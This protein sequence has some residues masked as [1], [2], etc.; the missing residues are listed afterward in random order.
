MSENKR[1]YK[2]NIDDLTPEEAQELLE[3]VK[4]MFN[5]P[6]INPET[7]VVDISNYSIPDEIEFNKPF[8]NPITGE[9]DF[10]K[11]KKLSLINRILKFFKI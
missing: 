1:V 10:N 5:K 9:F 11:P 6:V 3:K 7:G 2:I 4:R 8:V